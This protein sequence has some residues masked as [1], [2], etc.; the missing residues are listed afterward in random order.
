[1]SLGLFVM[2]LLL[3]VTSVFLILVVL[4]QRGRGGGLTGALGGMGG[5]SAFGA[6]AGDT[7]TRITIVTAIIWIT[8]CMLTIRIYNRPPE[9]IV[10]NRGLSAGD[11]G[12]LPDPEAPLGT[13]GFEL[14]PDDGD[15]SDE[16]GDEAPGEAPGEPDLGQPAGEGDLPPADELAPDQ[17]P[18]ESPPADAPA[19]EPAPGTEDDDDGDGQQPPPQSPPEPADDSDG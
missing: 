4:V 1:M 2:G 7:F 6:K 3:F 11:A 13:P 5:Q 9:P 8:L 16:E 14:P 12:S 17:P 15:V 10:Q 19:D 18:L